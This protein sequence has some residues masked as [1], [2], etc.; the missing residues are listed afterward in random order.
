M[1]VEQLLVP[2]IAG[3]DAVRT[4]SSAV[5]ALPGVRLVTVNLAMKSVRVEHDGSVRPEVLIQA[6]Q[7]AGYPEAAIL[8]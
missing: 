2:A 8:M 1:A 3:A 4:I 6:I 7:Q 5:G